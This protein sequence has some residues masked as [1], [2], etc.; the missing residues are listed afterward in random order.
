MVLGIH[1]NPADRPGYPSVRQ[2]LRPRRI[3]FVLGHITLCMQFL[4]TDDLK[5]QSQRGTH[6]N[7]WE[8][9]VCL[10]VLHG[11]SRE[12]SSVFFC[13]LSFD[14][15]R[16]IKTCCLLNLLR[17]GCPYRRI[18]TN[19]ACLLEVRKAISHGLV[20]PLYGAPNIVNNLIS[21]LTPIRCLQFLERYTE[22]MRPVYGTINLLREPHRF[23]F[24]G[25]V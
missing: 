11:L 20:G 25:N 9:T 22:A 7:Y 23:L 10:S 14:G 16:F 3:H 6:C 21:A 15:Q 8:K 18:H 4:Q 2:G 5:R 24:G 12:K 13:S 1:A 17:D 19:G